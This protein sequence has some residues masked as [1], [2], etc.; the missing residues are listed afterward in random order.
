MK[1]LLPFIFLANAAYA[2]S[3][4][5]TRGPAEEPT[6]AVDLCIRYDWACATHAGRD[7]TLEEVE[8]VNRQVNR[9][10]EITDIDQYGLYDNW[11]VLS[12]KGGDCED[13]A[14][15]KKHRL[16]ML[17]V[18]PK[19]L[20]LT[21]VLDKEN[22]VHAVLLWRTRH[23]DFILDNLTDRIIP[24]NETGYYFIRMQDPSQ[25]NKWLAI[26]K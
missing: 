24:W 1:F 16:V 9:A 21:V 3:Q 20:L 10:Q 6:G 22:Q 2:E 12:K 5:P 23:G 19:T 25:Y 11:S 13:Y 4:I 8:Q 17:G 18:D 7:A 15:T 14:L 26:L